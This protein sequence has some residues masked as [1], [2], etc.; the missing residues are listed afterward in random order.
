MKQA[1]PQMG[2]GQSWAPYD[3]DRS[4]GT[5]REDSHDGDAWGYLT[6]GRVRHRTGWTAPVAN[7]IDEWR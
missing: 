1:E 5:L 7:L 4:R 6:C 2:S 3:S